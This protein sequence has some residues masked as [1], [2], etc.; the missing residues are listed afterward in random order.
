MGAGKTEFSSHAIDPISYTQHPIG[1]CV[2]CLSMKRM[3]ACLFLAFVIMKDE[4]S[5]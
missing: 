5:T 2:F 4:N 3:F 1:S